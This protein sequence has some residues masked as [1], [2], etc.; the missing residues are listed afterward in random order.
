MDTVES[1]AQHAALVAA[2][3]DP[4]AFPHPTGPVESIET[5]ISTVV[6]AGEFAYKL[7]KPVNLGFVDFSTLP[8]RHR[9]CLE[10]IRLNR[11]GAP[12]LYLDVLPITGTLRRPRLSLIHI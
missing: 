6:L 9:F 5:H 7:K 1:L 10:E 4:A 11:R 3:C 8:L 12:D 2:L